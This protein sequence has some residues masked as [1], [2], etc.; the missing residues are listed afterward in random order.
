MFRIVT[1]TFSTVIDYS[2]FDSFDAAYQ[3]ML[4]NAKRY[5]KVQVL[6]KFGNEFKVRYN[7]R[8]Y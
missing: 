8:A 3:W 5:Y 2:D 1:V 4:F 6:E 7:Y